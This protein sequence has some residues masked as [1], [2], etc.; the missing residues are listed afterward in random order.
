MARHAHRPELVAEVLGIEPGTRVRG[1]HI[2]APL[3]SPRGG[4]KGAADGARV[5]PTLT[6]CEAMDDSLL[7]SIVEELM[8]HLRVEG[9]VSAD[10]SPGSWQFG[11]ERLLPTA[12]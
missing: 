5:W 1:E 9:W 10:G 12:H 2:A 8:A 4:L 11:T 7:R 6:D 3:L